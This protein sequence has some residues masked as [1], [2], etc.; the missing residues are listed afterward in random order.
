[1]TNTATKLVFRSTEEGVRKLVDG[2]CPGNGP[3]RVTAMRPPSTLRPGECY[4]SLPDGRFERRQLKPARMI[5]SP[6]R[7]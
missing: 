4:A 6:A 3:Y 2:L 5:G 7:R 1:M